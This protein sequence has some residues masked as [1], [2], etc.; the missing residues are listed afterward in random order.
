MY[1][2]RYV[3]HVTS[4]SSVTEKIQKADLRL[5]SDWRCRSIWSLGMDYRICAGGNMA[6]SACH[7]RLPS[8][9][10]LSALN[11]H[12]VIV[13]ISAVS[14]FSFRETPGVR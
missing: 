4:G 11:P 9:L 13:P 10:T 6:G 8:I 2:Q 14:V 3:I 12:S 7:V 1:V 5:Q